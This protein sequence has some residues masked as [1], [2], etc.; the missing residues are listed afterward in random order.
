VILG[1]G[2]NQSYLRDLCD[3]PD[4]VAGD[5]DTGFLSRELGGF[6]PRPTE[7]AMHWLEEVRRKGWTKSGLANASLRGIPESYRSPW[8]FYSG[9]EV[10]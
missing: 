7:E 2:T 5:T 10:K 8:S 9:G 6:L 3:H 4:V 1:L